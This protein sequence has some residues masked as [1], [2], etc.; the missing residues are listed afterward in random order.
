MTATTFDYARALAGQ[1]RDVRTRRT[2]T[3]SRRSRL[4]DVELR[5]SS[6]CGRRA[7]AWSSVRDMLKYV[8]MELDEGVLPDGKRYIA[9]EALLARRD[10]AGGDR[11]GRHRTAW[12]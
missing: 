9:K 7:A 3:A 5:R 11:Q 12:G 1:S 2:S 6:R 8:Q 4:M 10:A